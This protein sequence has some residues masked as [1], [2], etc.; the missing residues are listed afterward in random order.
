[1]W[2]EK[3][4]VVVHGTLGSLPLSPP[5]QQYKKRELATQGFIYH[6]TNNKM[7]PVRKESAQP[8]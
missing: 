2:L 7:K 4:T 3:E 1:M 5:A 8:C 6:F